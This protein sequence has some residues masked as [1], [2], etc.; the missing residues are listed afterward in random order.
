MRLP[1]NHNSHIMMFLGAFTPPY[2]Y[3]SFAHCLNQSIASVWEY[4]GRRPRIL[5]VLIKTLPPRHYIII[6]FTHVT[7]NGSSLRALGLTVQT[8][9][10]AAQY[11]LRSHLAP[12]VGVVVVNVKVSVVI[13]HLASALLLT[14]RIEHYHY[15]CH[16]H[17]YCQ[18]WKRDRRGTIITT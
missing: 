2:G 10:R 8:R 16:H 17:H 14:C 3:V 5:W 15:H 4:T 11:K 1:K 9:P 12:S 7:T 13:I 6:T 18:H